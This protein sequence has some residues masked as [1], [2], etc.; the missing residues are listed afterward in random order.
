MS[1]PEIDASITTSDTGAAGVRM[2]GVTK[3]FGSNVV[4]RDLDLDV[5]PGERVVIIGPSGSGKTTILRVIMT[6]ERPD[7][8]TIQVG[9]KQLYH[10]E[11]GDGLKPASEK[12]IRSVRS[13]I[14]MVFQ[15]FNLFPHMTALENIMLA[16]VKVHG[17]SKDDARTLGMDLLDKV[18]LGHAANQTPGQLSGGQKQRVAI[19]RSLATK[20]AVMLFDEVTSALD[21]ELVG[22]VLNVLRDIAEE[23]RTTMMLVTHEMHFAREV[24]DRVVMF[25]QGQIVESGPPSQILDEPREERTQ[26]FLGAVGEH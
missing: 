13:D 3:A 22:E 5:A 26:S 19:A 15:H 23:G 25:D 24:A 4:L 10:E 6:L 18:G 2:R 1:A 14:G 16:P 21:P 8:G 20:P 7:S 17:V 9:G 11:A 12:H